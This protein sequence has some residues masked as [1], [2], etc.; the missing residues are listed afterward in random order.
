MPTPIDVLLDPVSWIVFGIY[1]ALIA[2]EALAP[3]ARA[4]MGTAR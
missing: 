1:L 4:Q 2:W 3:A